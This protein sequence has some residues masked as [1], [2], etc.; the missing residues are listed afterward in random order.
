MNLRDDKAKLYAIW[1]KLLIWLL[2]HPA[3]TDKD[4]LQALT[5]FDNI[6]TRKLN[7]EDAL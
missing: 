5:L 3:I 1:S 6:L 2:H 4:Q 7:P